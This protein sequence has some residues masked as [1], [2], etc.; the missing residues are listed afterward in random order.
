MNLSHEPLTK[1]KQGNDHKIRVICCHPLDTSCPFAKN[2][3]IQGVESLICAAEKR[4]DDVHKRIQG[5]KNDILNGNL[6]VTYHI[7]CRAWYTSI[8]IIKYSQN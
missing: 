3:T 8:S 1:K 4:Q 5:I 7:K 2:S 6:T